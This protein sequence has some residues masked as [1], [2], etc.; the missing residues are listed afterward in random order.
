MTVTYPTDANEQPFPGL[1]IQKFL[2]WVFLASEIMFFTGLIVT[3]IVIRFNSSSWPVVAEVLNVPLVAAN[4]FIL[5]CSSVTMVLAFD[6][7]E[8]EQLQ[9]GRYF[10]LATM[11]LGIVF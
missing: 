1:A 10:L 4:T 5:I 11:A 3:Y 6:A 7:F 8:R 2:M 9:R